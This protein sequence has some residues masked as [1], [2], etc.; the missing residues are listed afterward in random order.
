MIRIN[1][2]GVPKPKKGKRAA[3][4]S[5]A[6]EGPNP[7]LVG[8]VVLLIGAVAMGAWWWK[9]NNDAKAIAQ[10]MDIASRKYQALQIVKQQ[11]DER[12]KQAEMYQR[13][14]KVI[15]DLRAQQSGPATLLTMIGDTVN[16]TDGVWLEKMVDTGSTID[17]QG[18]SLSVHGVANLMENLQK[19][20]KFKSVEIKETSQDTQIKDMQAFVFTLTCE[21][22]S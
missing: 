15:D 7:M 3:V 14:I 6:G 21:K 8:V 5:M 20:G 16:A 13:R 18:M 2:L 17:I 11:Y 19:S 22:K 1:L 4:P 12:A 10:R 9:L